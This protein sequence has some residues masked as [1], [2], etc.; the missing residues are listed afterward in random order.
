MH[1]GTNRGSRAPVAVAAS[2]QLGDATTAAPRSCSA[3]VG[4]AETAQHTEWLAAA[5]DK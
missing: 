2:M 4:A 1:V 5:L 3:T